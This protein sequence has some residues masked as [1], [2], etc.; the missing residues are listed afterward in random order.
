MP[1]EVRAFG[2]VEVKVLNQ[3]VDRR[4]IH[5]L[6]A[7]DGD[8]LIGRTAEVAAVNGGDRAKSRQPRQSFLVGDA[9]RR[10]AQGPM[11]GAIQ[12]FTPAEEV[13]VGIECERPGGLQRHAGALLSFAHK[14]LKAAIF[15]GVLEARP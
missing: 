8:V 7:S 11:P 10:N 6:D 4:L 5:I 13:P 1:R 9:T 15:D 2:R 14:P 3:P 12:R